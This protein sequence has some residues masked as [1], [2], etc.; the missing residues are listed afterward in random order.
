M[1]KLIA[2]TSAAC[3]GRE[4]P[5]ALIEAVIDGTAIDLGAALKRVMASGL[6]SRRG[7]PPDATYLFKHALVQDAAHGTLLRGRRRELHARIAQALVERFPATAESEPAIVAYHY[8]EAGL[9]GEA[10]GYWRKAG[11]LAAQR[12]PELVHGAQAALSGILCVGQAG[13]ATTTEIRYQV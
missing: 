3:I 7:T 6:V 10:I 8:T 5:H 2:E 9:A 11:Q 1:L 12:F 13:T 4:F